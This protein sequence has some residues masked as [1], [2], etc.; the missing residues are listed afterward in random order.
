M[1]IKRVV[2]GAIVGGITLHIIGYLIFDIAVADYYM[3][4][5]A[6]PAAFRDA[7]ILWSLVLGNFAFATL[8]TLGVAVRPGEPAMGS[9]FVTGAVVGFLGW[10]HF[11]FATYAYTNLWNF[12]IAIVDPLLEVVHAGITGAVIASV[13]AMVPKG[14]AIRPAE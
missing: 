14:A 9:G 5:R 12:P 2:V 4:N 6:T 3:A 8:I 7:P 13:M 11:D 10:F 1:D